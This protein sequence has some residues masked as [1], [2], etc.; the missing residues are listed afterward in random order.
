MI[1]KIYEITVMA[2]LL[3]F[4]AGHCLAAEAPEKSDAPRK[5]VTVTSDTME[6]DSKQNTV[7]FRGNVEAIEEFR[8]LSD[9]LFIYYDSNKEINEIEANGNV[10][11]YQEDKT[12]TSEKARYNRKER[13]I[14][15]TGSPQVRQCDDT[16]K[17]DRITVYL[18]KDNA[19][20]ESYGAGR[21]KAVIMPEKKCPENSGNRGENKQK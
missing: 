15:L 19:L 2:F 3:L 4:T 11:I 20:V 6:A 16:I 14:I 17:G 21:V 5:P 7:I 9:E 1:S 8:L 12:S 13:T 18:D 10:R